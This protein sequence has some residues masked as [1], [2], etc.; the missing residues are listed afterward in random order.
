MDLFASSLQ[1]LQMLLNK[2]EL[3]VTD[4]VDASYKRIAKVDDTVSAFLT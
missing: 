4:L 2:K 1:E 3:N